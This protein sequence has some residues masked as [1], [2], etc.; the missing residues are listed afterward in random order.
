MHFMLA[1]VLLF[2]LFVG[3]GIPSDE[4]LED[5]WVISEVTDDSAA[6]RAGLAEDDRILTVDGVPV[7]D[8]DDLVAVVEARPGESVSIVFERDGRQLA[9]TATIGSRETD[10]VETGFLG[11]RPSFAGG[12]PRASG[13]LRRGRGQ[14]RGLRTLGG[15]IDHRASARSS[16]RR[17]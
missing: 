16:R 2:A 4:V 15:T 12:R 6:E 3:Y 17:T 13:R 10:G 1:I 5:D 8:W 11:V 7:A 9:S 14:R